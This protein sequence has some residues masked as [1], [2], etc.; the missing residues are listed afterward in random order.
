MS[1]RI[2][3]FNHVETLEGGAERSLIDLLENLP[4]EKFEPFVVTPGEGDFSHACKKRGI[5]CDFH[6]SVWWVTNTNLDAW[7]YGMRRL[8][9]AVEKI[10]QIIREKNIDVVHTNSSVAPA[11][12]FAAALENKPHV[13]HV[14]EFLSHED[15]GLTAGPVS[16]DNLKDLILAMSSRV[17]V[18][19]Q[20]LAKEYMINENNEK[21]IITI[22]DG[23]DYRKFENCNKSKENIVLS[24]GAT[25]AA[26]GLEDLI[27]TAKIIHAKRKDVQFCVIGHVYPSRYKTGIQNKLRE[28]GLSGHVYLLGYQEDVVPYMSRAKV[29][30]LPSRSEGMSRVILEAMAAGLPVVSTDSGGPR[31]I[32]VDGQTGFLSPVG[33][34]EMMADNLFKILS[35]DHLAEQMGNYGKV[36]ARENFDLRKSS[37]QTFKVISDASNENQPKNISGLCEFL[38]TYIQEAGPRVLLGKKWAVMKPFI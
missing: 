22:P 2:L 11:A 36:R 27:E 14:R 15:L 35:D 37:A 13:W 20:A 17:I 24:I 1:L 19:S 18:I 26:K 16:P 23:I 7:L 31:D 21:K 30:C 6:P 12:A 10:R 4:K 32:V 29:F 33:D 3:F 38:L 9:E 28:K 8:P 34:P 25:S 5:K